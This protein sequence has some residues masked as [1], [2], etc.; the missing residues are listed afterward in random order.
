MQM[1]AVH[2]LH[3]HAQLLM[4]AFQ[5]INVVMVNVLSLNVQLAYVQEIRALNVQMVFVLH[6]Q[7]FV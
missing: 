7:D 5:A 4:D 2:L 3:H 1:E 6:P